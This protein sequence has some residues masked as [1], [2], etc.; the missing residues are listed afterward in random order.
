M[1]TSEDWIGDLRSQGATQAAAIEAL[2][3]LLIRGLRRS[4]SGRAGADE[5]FLEDTAQEA[6]LRVLDKL[7]TFEGRSR[8]TTWAM[9]IAIRLA[10]S[11]LR[12]KHW[13]DISL[14]A[15]TEDGTLRPEL[16]V[17]GHPSPKR[18]AEQQELLEALGRHIRESLTERQR[19]A[20]Q[21]EMAGM[22]LEE[23]ARRLDSNLNAVYKLTHDA[24]KRLRAA[25]EAEGYSLEDVTAAFA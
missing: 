10:I 6:A 1:R 16:A 11:D 9:A 4:F 5:G 22:P 13:K 7:D 23:I 3:E 19:R 20:I 17:D 15:A 12:R 25:L 18:R 14:D 8:F 24:R 2:R 21:A